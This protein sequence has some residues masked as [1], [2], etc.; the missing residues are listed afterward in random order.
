MWLYQPVPYQNRFLFIVL[1]Y[2][3]YVMYLVAYGKLVRGGVLSD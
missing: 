3:S 1:V 2:V